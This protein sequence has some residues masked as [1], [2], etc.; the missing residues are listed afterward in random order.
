MPVEI[1]ELQIHVTVNQQGEVQ[2]SAAPAAPEQEEESP[3][4]V[5]KCV[6]EIMEILHNNKER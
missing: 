2:D 3:D 1:R 5:H 4:L 6:E